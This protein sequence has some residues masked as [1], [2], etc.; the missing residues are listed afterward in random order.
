MRRL[1]SPRWML[2]HLGV[3]LLI[4]TM[5]NLAFWQLHRLD[6]K[7]AFNE[8]V[9]ANTAK[10]VVD[11]TKAAPTTLSSEWSRAAFTG[12]YDTEHSVTII[13]RSQDGAAG[14]DIAIPFTNEDGTVILVNRGFVPLSMT[15]PKTTT[16]KLTIVGY[17][18][19]TQKRGAVGAIDSTDPTNTEFHRFDLPLIAKATKTELLTSSY[20]QLIKEDPASTSQWPSAVAMPELDEGSHLSYAVQ[21]F[22]FSATAFTAWVFVV[23]RKLREPLSDLVAQEQTSA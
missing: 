12:T 4:V 3:A 8:R 13:N 14:Y 1:F 22:F 20:V 23:R 7:K 5:I 9:T 21:W 11:Y 16:E 10:P 15:A 19:A 6:E 18:R 17:I 2:I